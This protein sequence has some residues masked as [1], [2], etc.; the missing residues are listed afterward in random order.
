MPHD[1][2][3]SVLQYHFFINTL[4]LIKALLKKYPHKLIKAATKIR[5]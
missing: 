4:N 5:Y 2:P 1:E 3:Q